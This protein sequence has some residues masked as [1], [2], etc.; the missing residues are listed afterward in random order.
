M[1]QHHGDDAKERVGMRT[2]RV[3][4]TCMGVAC[5]VGAFQFWPQL[6]PNAVDTDG[7]G[8]DDRLEARLGTDPMKPD[9]DGDGLLD[10]WEV[11]GVIPAFAGPEGN[12][13]PVAIPGANAL[14]KDVYVEVDWMRDTGHTHAFRRAGR[15]RVEDAFTRAPVSNPSGE[16]GVNI[17]IDPDSLTYRG[18]YGID[19]AHA[20]VLV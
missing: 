14:R 8:L 5:L 11:F 16:F 1:V 12:A 13:L 2:R 19:I 7:D 17:H 3:L 18:M 20:D 9:T 10:G 15:D 6:A 4:L